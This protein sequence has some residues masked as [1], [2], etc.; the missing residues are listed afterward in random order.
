MLHSNGAI[1]PASRL[2]TRSLIRQ[3][4]FRYRA[5]LPDCFPLPEKHPQ[6][7]A[8][9]SRCAEGEENFEAKH[10]EVFE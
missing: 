5:H 3:H 8:L 4:N 9:P 10:Q 7:A 2:R 1:F 6:Q